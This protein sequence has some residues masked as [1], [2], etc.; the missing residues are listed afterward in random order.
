MVFET[1]EIFPIFPRISIFL[2]KK[3]K[4]VAPVVPM[5]AREPALV[6]LEDGKPR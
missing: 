6:P 4:K 1:S 3:E 5:A 2:S